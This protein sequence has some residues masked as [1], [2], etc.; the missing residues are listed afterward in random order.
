MRGKVLRAANH[1]F[2]HRPADAGVATQHGRCTD[3]VLQRAQDQRFA[4]QVGQHGRNAVGA[5]QRLLQQVRQRCGVTAAGTVDG[6]LLARCVGLEFLAAHALRQGDAGRQVLHQHRVQRTG[7]R[8]LLQPIAFAPGQFVSQVGAAQRQCLGMAD[9]NHCERGHHQVQRVAAPG[10]LHQPGAKR[11]V[12]QRH[13]ERIA[14]TG[15]VQHCPEQ[16]QALVGVRE[17]AD[18]HRLGRIEQVAFARSTPASGG[19]HRGPPAGVGAGAS[20]EQQHAQRLNRRRCPVDEFIEPLAQ[21]LSVFGGVVH[22][23]QRGLAPPPGTEV[24]LVKEPAQLGACDEPGVPACGAGLLA[25]FEREPR[26]AAA[27]TTDKHAGQQG[28]GVAQVSMQTGKF[29]LATEQWCGARVR[30]ESVQVLA[31]LSP[32]HVPREP[33]MRPAGGNG[34]AVA[35]DLYDRVAVADVARLL[36]HRGFSATAVR[37]SSRC[38]RSQRSESS[39]CC[40]RVCRQFG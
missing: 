35:H 23:D 20:L 37:L 2:G 19:E 1:R 28:P 34:V 17:C 10:Q 25:Q 22:H 31:D 3:V 33:E 4:D 8:Q 18:R 16:G 9:S 26:L 32:S 13:A 21:Q 11:N 29:R 36:C 15:L 5:R 27:T 24:L 7:P 39:C 6:D 38:Y 40:R 30:R 12:V 14:R